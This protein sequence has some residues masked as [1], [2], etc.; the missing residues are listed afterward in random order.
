MC[1]EAIRREMKEA[2]IFCWQIADKLGVSESTFFRWMRRELP[3]ERRR[4]IM[5]AVRKAKAG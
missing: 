3:E 2:G 5:A 1:N 4:E